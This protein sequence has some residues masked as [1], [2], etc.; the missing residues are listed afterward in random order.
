M[1]KTSVRQL[2]ELVKAGLWGT[3]LDCQ[4]FQAQ[5]VDWDQLLAL[6][7]QQ[8]VIGIVTD[9]LTML[10]ATLRPPKNKYFLFIKKTS[11][12]EKEN[13]KLYDLVPTLCSELDQRGIKT[14][15]LKGQGIGLCYRNP[16]R[17][18]SGDVDLFVGLNATDYQRAKD[19]IMELGAKE[20]EI[21]DFRQHAEYSWHD[22]IVELHGHIGMKVSR[23]FNRTFPQ[24]MQRCVDGEEC[25]RKK[26]GATHI[27]Y[28]PPYRFD[29]IFI[30]AHAI[31]HYM[32]S[33]VGL[34]QICDWMC[35]LVKN[36]DK[37]DQKLLEQ[38][39]EELGLAKFWK[40]FG[41]MAVHCLGMKK[42]L[43]P[44]YDDTFRGKDERLLRHIFTTGNFGY[45]QRKKQQV[46]GNQVLK[47]LKTFYG[48][49]Y[50]YWDNVWV[51]PRETLYCFKFF[52][53][54]GIRNLQ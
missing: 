4:S 9:A 44:L 30:F 49:L 48:Q 1:L 35:F 25:V 3:P 31:N 45:L 53:T 19:A 52:V 2:I 13:V 34:R 16:Y 14:W 50:I 11:E 54:K 40:M 17:R 23:Q 43:M 21:W 32:T 10:P 37:I 7:D 47:K 5:R 20:T 39:L 29:A 18:T 46:G 26:A 22:I 51:F 27:I 38:D 41:A 15:L 8:T 24:W 42:E 36:H 12:I 6:S 28:M 33:G